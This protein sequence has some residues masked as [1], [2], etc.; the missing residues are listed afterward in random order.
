VFSVDV[1]IR[2]TLA[3]AAML[4]AA[5]AS[6]GARTAAPKLVWVHCYSTA[7]V[8]CNASAQTTKQASVVETGSLEVGASGLA[9]KSRVLIPVRRGSVRGTRWV[10]GT[11]VRSTRLV[12]PVPGDAVG[13]T[14]K[15]F[16]PGAG[17]SNGIKVAVTAPPPKPAGDSTALGDTGM[18]IWELPQSQ[19]GDLA[20][21]A[22]AAAIYGVKT[23]FLKSGDGTS[24]WS[25]Q[26]T[27]AVVATLKA[28][29]LHVCAWQYVYGSD[30]IG[31]AA[32]GIESAQAGADCLIIDAEGEYEGKYAQAQQYMATLRQALGPS[33]PIGLASFPYVDLHPA[34]PYSVFLE[35]GG[36][37]YNLPQMYWQDIG[38]AVDTVYAHTWPVN[39]VYGAKIYPLGQLYNNPSAADILNFRADAQAYG[40]TGESWFDWQ[41]ATLTGFSSLSTLFTPAAPAAT[42]YPALQSGSKGDLVVWAQEHLVT[43]GQQLTIDGQFGPMTT[44]AVQAFQTAHALPA[45]GVLDAT[46]WPVLLALIPTEPNWSTTTAPADARD[47]ST[48]AALARSPGRTGPASARLPTIRD[49][50]PPALGRGR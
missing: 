40:A 23:V 6:A 17:T 10:L 36:A 50:I 19:G 45:T 22:S 4:L 37:R 15:V 33:Y 14:I 46:T 39:Q 27:P 32:V 9:A 2:A 47:Y 38:D 7:L 44:A 11:L 30:P 5:P 3:I 13:G 1:R 28:A 20:S 26:F 48:K 24:L 12:V 34:F 42:T 49:E 16:S 35:P 18:W 31:E 29:G 25:T 43:A 41:S 21:I 8:A